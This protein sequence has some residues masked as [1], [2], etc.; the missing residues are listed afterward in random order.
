M[1]KNRTPILIFYA[2]CALTAILCSLP[3]FGAQNI[4]YTIIF[5]LL[6]VVYIARARWPKENSFEENHSTYIIR[7]IWIYSALASFGIV[8]AG[9]IIGQNAN[10]DA[11]APMLDAMG[12][13]IEPSDAEAKSWM[14]QYYADNADLIE[15][16]AR[17]WLFPAQIYLV[18]RTARGAVRAY[19]NYRISKPKSWF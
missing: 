8:G 7:T 3:D 12:T 1:E 13:G 18:Y 14:L 11:L 10:P 17:I 9:M 16:T 15:R 19:K 5:F 6:I 4:G 2:A